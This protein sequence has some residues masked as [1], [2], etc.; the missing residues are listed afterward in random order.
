M[1]ER[2]ESKRSLLES[3]AIGNLKSMGSDRAR[4]KEW[5]DKLKNALGELR[6]GS[7]KI[8]EWVGK[9]RDRQITEAD[10]KEEEFEQEE[11]KADAGAGVGVRARTSTAKPQRHPW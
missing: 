4:F 6:G 7:R 8:L 9:R 2:R 11:A 5:D 10:Y 3:K 1:G